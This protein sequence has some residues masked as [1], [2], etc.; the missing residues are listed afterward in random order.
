MF[1]SHD[2]GMGASAFCQD[3]RMVQNGP[4]RW[5]CALGWRLQL[6]NEWL[7]DVHMNDM[8]PAA[9]VKLQDHAG[10]IGKKLPIIMT[11]NCDL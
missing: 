8:Q 3:V 10:R 6:Q 7:Y 9:N 2:N 5:H 11:D 1:H 4:E